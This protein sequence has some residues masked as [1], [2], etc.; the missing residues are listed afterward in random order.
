MATQV[1]WRRGTHAQVL[2]FVGAL[3]EV[4]IDTTQNRLV[5]QD[6][7]TA[8]GWPVALLQDILEDLP[9]W[10]TVTGTADAI[11]LTGVNPIPALVA[12]TQANFTA[13]GTNAT[14]TPTI[15]LDGKGAGTVRKYNAA[16]VAGDITSGLTYTVYWDG[17]YWQLFGVPF[18]GGVVPYGVTIS[19]GGLTVSAGGAAI[20]GNSTIT[21]T[22]G[23]VTGLTVASG[24]ASITGNVALTASSLLQNSTTIAA[25]ATTDLSTVSGNLVSVTGSGG[26]ITSL[27]TVQAGAVFVL[28]MVGAPIFTYNG[29]SLLIPGGANYASAA[30]D[31]ILAFSLGGGN[32]EI[33]PLPWSGGS[34]IPPSIAANLPPAVNLSIV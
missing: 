21:G 29:T 9:L 7:V 26:P 32:W 19:S 12:G 24:G 28:K 30:N 8:G 25:A 27:G 4:V 10:K 6:G 22:L 5:V 34:I 3:G 16:L 17:A 18:R 20:T 11:I 23:G 31:I 14:T 2:A 15:N 1:Q 13:T 33:V